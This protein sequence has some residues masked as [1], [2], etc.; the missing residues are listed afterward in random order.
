MR[1]TD[2]IH[3]QELPA[4]GL[5]MLYLS[6][7]KD[8][9]GPRT[10]LNCFHVC[11]G[12]LGSPA[13]GS[14]TVIVE[15][16]EQLCGSVG[17]QHRSHPLKLEAVHREAARLIGSAAFQTSEAALHSAPPLTAPVHACVCVQARARA[18]GDAQHGLAWCEPAL[19]Y[20]IVRYCAHAR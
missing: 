11:S 12:W 13:K 6:M 17:A 10:H 8:P 20:T 9:P 15:H 18:L 14:G 1:I 5:Q 19:S 4:A 16:P 7:G 3:I 2:V